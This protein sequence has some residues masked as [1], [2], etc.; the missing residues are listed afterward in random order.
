MEMLGLN[1]KNLQWEFRQ[2]QE[3]KRGS[4]LREISPYQDMDGQEF[5][6]YL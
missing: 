6:L 4:R 5:S 1:G 2:G 3:D